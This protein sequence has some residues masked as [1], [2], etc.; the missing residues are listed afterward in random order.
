QQ[1]GVELDAADGALQATKKDGQWVRFDQ[2]PRAQQ[3][4]VNAAVSAALETLAQVPQL[5]QLPAGSE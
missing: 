3:Q 2:V 5:L 1:I 4:S